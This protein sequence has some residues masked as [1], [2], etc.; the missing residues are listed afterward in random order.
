MF[1]IISYFG[2]VTLLTYVSRQYRQ[3]SQRHVELGILCLL[4]KDKIPISNIQPELQLLFYRLA[5]QNFSP[6]KLPERKNTSQRFN[7]TV[8]FPHDNLTKTKNN[9]TLGNGQNGS[10]GPSCGKFEYSFICSIKKF[11]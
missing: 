1:N 10:F 9:H 11:L 2:N 8:N 3:F 7:K 5:V 6:K 4:D